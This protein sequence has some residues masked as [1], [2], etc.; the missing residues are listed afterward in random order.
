MRVRLFISMGTTAIAVSDG[1]RA[2]DYLLQLLPDVRL[3]GPLCAA[4]GR[5]Y[6]AS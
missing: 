6:L 2:R 4:A 3:G 5:G 1:Y